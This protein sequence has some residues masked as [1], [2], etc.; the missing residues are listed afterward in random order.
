MGDLGT[1]DVTTYRPRVTQNVDNADRTDYL[2]AQALQSLSFHDV[3]DCDQLRIGFD[4][5]CQLAFGSKPHDDCSDINVFNGVRRR[6]SEQKTNDNQITFAYPIAQNEDDS[7]NFVHENGIM[8]MTIK[9]AE[10]GAPQTFA[11]AATIFLA[12]ILL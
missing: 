1:M 4:L 9:S 7:K 6:R 8:T 5:T 2:D 3:E 11:S 10:G 12:A